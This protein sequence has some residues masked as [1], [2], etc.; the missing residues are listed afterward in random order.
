M[1]TNR[2]MK[3]VIAIA[4]VVDT[5]QNI[6]IN[7]RYCM[8][9]N[10]GTGPLYIDTKKTSAA[11]TGFLIP[12]STTLPMELTCMGNLSVISTAAGTSVSVMILE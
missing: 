5:A 3:E 8:I 12:A 6:P 11:T 4:S 9:S 7:G 1:F 2:V 10:T